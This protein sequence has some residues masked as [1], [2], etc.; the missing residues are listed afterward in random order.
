MFTGLESDTKEIWES[1]TIKRS[2]DLEFLLYSGIN[3]L[4]LQNS[5]FFKKF[6]DRNICSP[7]VSRGRTKAKAHTS[8]LF[9]H[10]FMLM[11]AP[12]RAVANTDDTEV[13]PSVFINIL[14]NLIKTY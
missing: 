5:A 2:V 11:C 9:I 3:G 12:P 8:I 10:G 7:S 6:Y 4:F 13:M 14:S 1:A